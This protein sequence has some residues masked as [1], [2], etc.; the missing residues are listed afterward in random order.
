VLLS[1]EELRFGPSGSDCVFCTFRR[2]LKVW[3]KR[4]KCMA[5]AAPSSRLMVLLFS[6]IVGSSD[7]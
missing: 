1:P 2:G 4:V 3:E 5:E 6:D 7:L